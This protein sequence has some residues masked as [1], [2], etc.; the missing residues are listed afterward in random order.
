MQTHGGINAENAILAAEREFRVRVLVDWNNDG[1]F[2]HAL[3]DLSKFA[4]NITVDRALKGSIPEEIMMIEGSS[5][6]QLSFTIGGEYNGLQFPSVFSPYNGLSPLYNKDQ[7]GAEVSY[8]IGIETVVGT[9]WYRQFIGNIS[10]ISPDRADNSVKIAA[11]DRVEKLRRPVILAPWAISDYWLNRG[12]RLAQLSDSQVIIQNCLQL[13]D[14]SASKWRPPVA[15][16]LKLV[17]GET[18]E[19]ISCFIPGAGGINPTTGWIDNSQ[20]FTFPNTEA[21]VQLY[22]TNTQVHPNSPEPTKRPFGFAAMNTNG[23]GDFKKYWVTDRDKIE[24]GGTHFLSMV[25]NLAGSSWHVTAPLTTLYEFRCG[26]NRVL[27]IHI[28]NNQV[29]TSLTNENNGFIGETAK[30]TL[31]AQDHVEIYAQ[32][33]T[34]TQ[35]GT[36][37]FLR[38]GSADTGGWVTIAG[39]WPGDTWNDQLVGLLLVRHR[40]AMQDIGYGFRRLAGTTPGGP[41]NERNVWKQAKYAA[42]LDAGANSLSFMPKVNGDD[43]WDVITSVAAA[44][45]GSVFWDENGVF[46]FWNYNTIKAKQDTIVRTLSTDDV[47][48][49]S[50]TNSFD[51]VRNMYSVE[52][53]KRVGFNFNRIY[54]SRSL[55][56]F[57]VPGGSIRRFEIYVDNVQFMEP[58]YM[59]RH[60]KFAPGTGNGAGDA[61]PQWNDYSRHAYVMQLLYGD[62]WRE[63]AFDNVTLDVKSWFDSRGVMIVQIVNPWSEPARLAVSDQPTVGNA[64]SQAAMRIAGT[65]INKFDPTSFQTIDLGSVSKYG[66]RNFK[67]SGDWYQQDYNAEGLM[68]VLLPRTVKPIPTTEEIELPGDPRLQLGDT[69]RLQDPDGLGEELRL[70]VFGISRTFSRDQGLTDHLSVELLRPAGLGIWDSSQYGRWD[71]SMIWS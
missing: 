70:Q 41:G 35:T 8:D 22:N 20:A 29:W 10:S 7:V 65:A 51:S 56:E 69:M 31:P 34:T 27:R 42:V 53:N 50:I 15:E 68:S 25:L 33:D 64:S 38:V 37:A 12:R 1:L 49:L 58:A 47:T 46:R 71:Q 66:P 54:E 6:A 16:E 55:D 57:Y 23:D 17:S 4:D 21:G 9:I 39:G 18:T 24:I 60:T 3:S 2:N 14:V 11:F 26:Q 67:A 19:F 59:A 40:V 13:C 28:Q 5:A 36:R 43:A 30:F 62:G 63:P 32:W 61:F 45:F 52:A 48:Q 44:E